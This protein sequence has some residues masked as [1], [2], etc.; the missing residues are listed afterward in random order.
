MGSHGGEEKEASAARV[1]G[2]TPGA[3]SQPLGENAKADTRIARDFCA[4][5]AHE[6][7]RVEC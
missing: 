3:L 4:R 7:H 2:K 6:I 1:Q 5:V